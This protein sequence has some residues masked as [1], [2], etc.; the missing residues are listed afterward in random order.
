V[1]W[2]RLFAFRLPATFGPSP[3]LPAAPAR[4]SEWPTTHPEAGSVTSAGGPLLVKLSLS[5]TNS[6]RSA[7]WEQRKWAHFPLTLLALRRLIL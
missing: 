6:E 4:S 3:S 1:A 2:D 5:C 7:V